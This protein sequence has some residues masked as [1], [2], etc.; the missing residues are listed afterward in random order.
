[1]IE[2]IKEITKNEM[3]FHGMND[4]SFHEYLNESL[5][6]EGTNYIKSHTTI[7][8]MRVHGKA[9][10][11]DILEDMLSVYPFSD[12]R[13]LFVL[14]ILA[15]KKPHVWGFGGLVW[16]LKSSKIPKAE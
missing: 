3:A 14:R 11:T 13:F 9:P 15:I 16:N 4:R 7:I 6:K 12:R 1:M 5:S 8:G 2:E 10:N